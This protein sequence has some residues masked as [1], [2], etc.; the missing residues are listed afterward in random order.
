MRLA[1]L[2]FLL[3]AALI[4]ASS[5]RAAE[6]EVPRKVLA[7]YAESQIRS[8]VK[9]VFYL[10]LHQ[11]AELPLNHLGL[12]VDYREAVKSLPA[13]EEL[14]GYRAL[15][16]WFTDPFNLP[17]PRPM[18]R[19][20]SRAMDAGLRVVVLGNPGVY[21][22]AGGL[23][24]LPAE[25]AS[26]L[27]E[28]G[29]EFSEGR[30]VDP[31]SVS[32]S[33]AEKGVLGFE[34]RLDPSASGV[35]PVVR[36]SPQSRVML[37]LSLSGVGKSEPVGVTPRGAVALNPFFLY[38]NYDVD[39]AQFRWILDPFAFFEAAFGLEGLPRPDVT[40]LNGRRV[41][42]SHIDGDAFFNRSEVDRRQYSGEVFYRDFLLRHSSSPF[43]V[44]YVMGYYDLSV[45]GDPATMDLS[46]DIMNLPNVEPA[47]HGYAHPLVWRTGE[48]A[49]KV[50]R[51]TMDSRREIEG[52][53]HMLNAMFLPA[54]KHTRFF[55]WT[56]DCVP[57]ESD[58][59]LVRDAG[60]IEMNG[61]GGRFDKEF[62]SYAYLFGL[63]RQVGGL[64]QTYAPAFN[65]NEFTG[66]WSERFYGYRDAVETF[67]NT[68]APRR[69]KPVDVYIHFY[70]AEKYAAVKSLRGVYDWALAQPYIPVWASRYVDSVRDFYAMRIVR[71]GPRSFHALGGPMM[72][73]LRFDATREVPDLAASKGVI[74]WRH[75][76]GSLYVFLDES[77]QRSVVLAPRPG[78][79]YALK[80][81]NF[82]VRRWRTDGDR[83]RFDRQG[84]WE[85]SFT[86]R[87]CAP[88]R[89]YLVTSAGK[90]LRVAA[91]KDGLLH[92][93]FPD[94]EKGGP[95]RPVS[96]EPAP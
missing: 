46:R 78:P 12:A 1:L 39:P 83:L 75:E 92:V 34:R 60:M 11:H 77:A 62:P 24:K 48:V 65:E 76:L 95:A 36:L 19:L 47:S 86:L 4:A 2:P 17:D 27:K 16:T 32:V 51:Y 28:L 33:Y 56:G 89:T 49:L 63:S 58:L 88:G 29:A 53:S 79:G 43:T 72:R 80:E 74:G 23:T 84:W 90:T 41:Y 91:D 37:R 15:V 52:S 42:M 10:P 82:E 73:T 69:V 9:D 57:G 45:F 66:L 3:P 5:S 96:V 7:L 20:M 31:L 87:G 44:S 54:A 40:T 30:T 59:A 25:C 81:A 21:V 64:R 38:A 22:R 50:P 55:L 13:P 67:K 71:T 18:C 14:K 61:G 85:G 26:M 35:V 8:G 93:R 68:G 6:T 94:S 70:S